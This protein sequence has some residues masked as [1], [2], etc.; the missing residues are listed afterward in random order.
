MRAAAIVLIVASAL[1][2]ARSSSSSQPAAATSSAST[3]AP[4]SPPLAEVTAA[5]E[6]G[7][8]DLTFSLVEREKLAAGGERLRARGLHRGAVVEFDVELGAT[9]KGA[10]SPPIYVFSGVVTLKSVGNDASLVRVLDA[11]YGTKLAPKRMKKATKL[12][13]IALEGNPSALDAGPVRMKVFYESGDE[14]SGA[15]FFLN[16]DATKRIVELRE[17]DEEYRMPL[18]RALME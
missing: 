9:W 5:S 12:A 16:V 13:A 8:H 2:C 14:A 18:V 1:G 15:E 10:D 11:V 3:R 6:E 4:S 7:F 17:K